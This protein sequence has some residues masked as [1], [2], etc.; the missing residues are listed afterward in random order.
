MQLLNE[1]FVPSVALFSTLSG[2]SKITTKEAMYRDQ[3][4]LEELSEL[5]ASREIHDV[6]DAQIDYMWFATEALYLLKGEMYTFSDIDGEMP[7]LSEDLALAELEDRL[8]YITICLHSSYCYNS[9]IAHQDMETRLKT[10]ILEAYF[11]FLATCE[12]YGIDPELAINEV[13]DANMSKFY[14]N[15]QDAVDDATERG[16]DYEVKQ[17][18]EAY[19][20]IRSSDQKTMKAKHFK[21]PNWDWIYE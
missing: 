15:E 19:A 8:Q 13:V 10:L 20:I 9:L 18:G 12:V 1:V 5:F 16:T 2:R 4:L 21:A 3:F 11:I 7:G 14:F 6:L 17:V